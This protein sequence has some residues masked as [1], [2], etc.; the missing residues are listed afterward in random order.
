M[1]KRWL[2]LIS[3]A[4]FALMLTACGSREAQTIE[5]FT[6]IM[7]QAG[8]YVEHGS[9]E[10]LSVAW[11]IDAEERFQIA[12]YVFESE[13]EANRAFDEIRSNFNSITTGA[14]SRSAVNGSNHNIYRLIS[15]GTIFRASRIENTL[16]FVMTDEA[17]GDYVDNGLDLIGYR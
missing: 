4:L 12:F 2:L 7:E 15:R 13:F 9:D 1:K 14:V 8:F 6:E 3:M 10:M 5:G 11:A 16:V 17:Y